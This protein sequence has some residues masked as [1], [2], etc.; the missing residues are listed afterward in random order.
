MQSA[1]VRIISYQGIVPTWMIVQVE[2]GGRGHKAGSNSVEMTTNL[3]FTT[4]GEDIN[5]TPVYTGRFDLDTQEY[6]PRANRDNQATSTL[7]KTY[8]MSNSRSG[9]RTNL[10]L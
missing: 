1:L 8:P 2:F 3:M 6:P 7:P 4:D 9:G 10:N 5:S